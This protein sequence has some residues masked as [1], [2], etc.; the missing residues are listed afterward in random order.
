M[1]QADCRFMSPKDLRAFLNP[2]KPISP[3]EIIKE[4]MRAGESKEDYVEVKPLK[5]SKPTVAARS[6]TDPIPYPRTAPQ[7][8]D[9]FGGYNAPA[10]FP[11]TITGPITAG[12][13]TADQVHTNH[14]YS[15]SSG[16]EVIDL[17]AGKVD[18]VDTNLINVDEIT[19]QQIEFLSST[20]LP[21]TALKDCGFQS[22]TYAILGGGGNNFSGGSGNYVFT[23]IGP[24]FSLYVSVFLGTSNVNAPGQHLQNISFTPALP[25]DAVPVISQVFRINL[26]TT[27]SGYAS[28]TAEFPVG[29]PAFLQ[30]R[31][32]DL[33]TEYQWTT[34]AANQGW[35]TMNLSWIIGE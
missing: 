15:I 28:G 20:P 4:A 34:A 22:G 31:D 9:A 11:L 30:I 29:D 35:S 2:I 23:Q 5:A 16:S 21:A 25:E 17:S 18:L 32:S 3:S 33:N 10:P 6:L 14:I 8:S 27:T 24:V 12:S 1:S 13:L 7:I 19:A 26:I